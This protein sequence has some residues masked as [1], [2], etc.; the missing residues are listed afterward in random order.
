[1]VSFNRASL[2][3]MSKLTLVSIEDVMLDRVKEIP[4]NIFSLFNDGTVREFLGEKASD[5]TSR[6]ME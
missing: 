6:T 4:E 2:L 3:G 1:M 5:T